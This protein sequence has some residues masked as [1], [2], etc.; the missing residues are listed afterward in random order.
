[1]KVAYALDLKKEMVLYYQCLQT[2]MES[3]GR[4]IVVE[5]GDFVG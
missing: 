1:M 4:R 2:R 5:R 3:T